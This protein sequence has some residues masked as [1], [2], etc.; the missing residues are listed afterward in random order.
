MSRHDYK[1][2]QEIAAAR[3]TPY[4]LCTAIV[5]TLCVVK[6]TSPLRARSGAAFWSPS[7]LFFLARLRSSTHPEFDVNSDPSS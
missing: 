1:Y 6:L 4:F 5:R 2:S 7:L 3:P